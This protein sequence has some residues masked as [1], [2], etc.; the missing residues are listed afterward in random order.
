MAIRE[1]NKEYTGIHIN[2]KPIQEIWIFIE[3]AWRIIYQAIRSCFGA[4]F[5]RGDKPW[6]G[7]D[8]WKG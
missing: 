5:W 7:N 1:G 6:I 4:G 8:A 2:K 3:G